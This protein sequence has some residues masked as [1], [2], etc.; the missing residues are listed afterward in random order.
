MNRKLL[1]TSLFGLLCGLVFAQPN[2]IVIL[3]DDQGYAHL[4]A[5]KDQYDT[6]GMNEAYLEAANSCMPTVDRLAAEGVRFLN[7]HA[8]PTCFPSRTMLMSSRYPQSLGVYSNLDMWKGGPDPSAVFPV[9]ALNEAG[10]ATAM[11]GKW[12]LGTKLN[13]HPNDKGFDYYFGF[14][15]AQTEKY[16]STI[17]Y[18]NRTKTPAIGFLADQ[19]TNEAT[20]FIRNTGGDP[21]FIYLCYNDPHG[22]RPDAPQHYRNK[23]NTGSSNVNNFYAYI[24]AVDVGIDSVLSALEDIGQ[25][26]NT[27]IF[28]ASDNGPT[29]GMP[30]PSAGDL[31]WY[32]RSLYEGG[33]RV[34]AVAWWPENIAAAQTNTDLISFLDVMPTMLDA[35]GVDMP[36]EENYDGRSFLDHITNVSTDTFRYDPLFW[37]GDSYPDSPV[38]KANWKQWQVD[39]PEVSEWAWF[40][41]GWFVIQDQWKLID[42]GY[43]GEKLYNLE[44]D[45]G[46]KNDL[47]DDNPMVVEELRDHFRSFMQNKPPPFGWDIEKWE[48]YFTIGGD[49]IPFDSIPVMLTI[50]LLDGSTGSPLENAWIKL[51][52]L[53]QKTGKEGEVVFQELLKGLHDLNLYPEHHVE[54]IGREISIISDTLIEIELDMKEYVVDLEVRDKLSGCPVLNAII[55][56]DDQE[57]QTDIAGMAET[58]ASYGSYDITVSREYFKSYSANNTVKSDTSYRIDLQRTLADLEFKVYYQLNL[59]EDISI[60]M[61]EKQEITNEKG[62][63]LFQ[64]LP[65]YTQHNYTLEGEGY[66]PY[67]GNIVLQ[68][69]TSVIVRMDLTGLSAYQN[70]AHFSFYPNPAHDQLTIAGNMNY[71]PFR[72]LALDGRE[73]IEA[74]IT[75]DPYLLDISELESGIYLL[76]LGPAGRNIFQKTD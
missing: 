63:A 6:Q 41:P 7:C 54:L 49:T 73:L 30:D 14:N 1:L 66:S 17:L 69:D 70:I 4:G 31:R 56:F 33:V 15:S 13:Q 40:P 38:W 3:S 55:E 62:M 16:G 48:K 53:Q 71:L 64:A 2:I 39:F 21:F 28:F 18:R 36:A 45:I 5:F 46:E 19:V 65:V 10:Y 29:D 61:G 67:E 72:V 20:N 32:K 11:I 68:N 44:E 43:A 12:H 27:I 8:A 57:L 34:P 23:F 51:D 58:K 24:N 74:R 59:L 76:D 37:A 60:S 47:F 35:V 50:R 22:P 26:D 25:I 9:K 52:S 42:D 75:S